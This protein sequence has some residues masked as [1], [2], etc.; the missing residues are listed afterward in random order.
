MTCNRGNLFTRDDTF[1]GVC[2][3]LGQDLGVSPLWFR[4]A[5]PLALF[6][7][8]AMAAAAYVA[9]G[10]LVLASRLLFPDRGRDAVAVTSAP[11]KAVEPANEVEALPLAA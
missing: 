3:G 8:P 2:E 7:N 6:F 4:V 11:A 9:A 10:V 1:F 5:F